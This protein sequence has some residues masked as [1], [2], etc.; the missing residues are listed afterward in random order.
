MNILWWGSGTKIISEEDISGLM[1]RIH[2]P[3]SQYVLGHMIWS[4]DLKG[5]NP[6]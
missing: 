4:S 5:R 1:A 6:I 3:F 2:R